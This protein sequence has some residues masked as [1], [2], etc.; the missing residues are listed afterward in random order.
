MGACVCTRE[1]PSSPE[2]VEA[3]LRRR[4]DVRMIRDTSTHVVARDKVCGCQRDAFSAFPKFRWQDVH[5]LVKDHRAG[6][7]HENFNGALD[8]TALAPNVLEGR[9]L[10][11]TQDFSCCYQSFLRAKRASGTD[12][13]CVIFGCFA[14][15]CQESTCCALHYPLAVHLTRGYAFSLSRGVFAPPDIVE[16]RHLCP[17]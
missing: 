10:L 7:S 13:V 15:V 2:F 14:R 5:F 9:R 3:D 12:T 11:C 8:A 1:R 16:R 4:T 6:R 17:S